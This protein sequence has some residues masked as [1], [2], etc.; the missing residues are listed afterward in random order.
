MLVLSRHRSEQI[1]IETPDGT[2]IDV[3]AVEIRGDK[4]RIGITAPRDYQVHRQEVWE[5]IQRQK[6]R[7][8]GES[9][10]D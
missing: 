5:A 7:E 1:K 6:K 10:P 9:M 4:V 3:M 8:S 2:L